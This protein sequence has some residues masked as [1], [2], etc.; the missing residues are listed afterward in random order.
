MACRH[1]PRGWLAVIEAI[2]ER[3]G[4]FQFLKP[5][6]DRAFLAN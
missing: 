1:E 5:L 4:Q 6:L 2:F 3:D